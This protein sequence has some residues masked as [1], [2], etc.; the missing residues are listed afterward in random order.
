MP[1]FETPPK[2]RPLV[3][4]NRMV[5]QIP[6]VASDNMNA[7]R[8]ASEHLAGAGVREI[9]YLAG[10]RRPG[11]TGCVGRDCAQRPGTG[12]Q[13]EADR[14]ERAHDGRWRVGSDEVAWQPDAGV[15]AYNDLLAIGFIQEVMLA[16]CPGTRG[17]LRDWLRQHPRLIP[18]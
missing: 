18:G 11:L 4:L 8:K 10:P 7:M 3:M 1:L 12:S 15:I 9:T 16:G 5:G 13:G 14:T 6:S 2:H 17:R